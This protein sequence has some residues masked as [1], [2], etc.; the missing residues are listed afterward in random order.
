[1]GRWP[2]WGGGRCGE[3]AVVK[4]WPLWGGG[5][6]GEV[7]VVGRWP[8]CGGGRCGEVAVSRE[9]WPLWGDGRCGELGDGRCGE[10]G[11]SGGS[12]VFRIKDWGLVLQTLS[13]NHCC[14]VFDE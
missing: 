14:T 6:C 10:L 11:V 3:V 1:M 4:R 13:A 5:R 9:K 12:T 2:L 7:A 8:L